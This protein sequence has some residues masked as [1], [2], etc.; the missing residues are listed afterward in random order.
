MDNNNNDDDDT[1]SIL[2]L[3]SVFRTRDWTV[4]SNNFFLLRVPIHDRIRT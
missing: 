2:L 1:D 3:C 4:V